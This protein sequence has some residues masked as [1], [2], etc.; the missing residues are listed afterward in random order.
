MHAAKGHPEPLNLDLDDARRRY[1]HALAP[2]DRERHPFYAELCDCLG[3]DHL[4]L[5]LLSEVRATQ[6]N[7]MLILAALQLL[8]LRRHVVLGPL[9]DRVRRGELV[10]VTTDVET[11][12]NVLHDDPALVRGELWRS[13]QT[14]E[15]GR[16]AV[17]QALVSELARGQ[18]VI[19]VIEVGS[20]A[21]IN[22]HFERFRVRELDDHDALTLEC[23]DLGGAYERTL[24][25]IARRVGI[26]PNPLELANLDDQQWLKACLWPEDRRRHE[27]FDAVVAAWPTWEPVEVL[28]GSAR[29][30]FDEALALTNDAF[31]IIVNTWVLFYLSDEER[32]WFLARAHDAAREGGRATIS[33][34]S[35]L[36]AIEGIDPTQRPAQR[37]ASRI[38][39]AREFG[40]PE[41]WGWCHPHG[42]WLEKVHS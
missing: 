19:N 34:E 27:R 17:L 39:V 35:P 5:T 31:T 11:V 9:Y 18:R 40:A 15:P 33:V 37:G 6:R 29:E 10:D 16:S 7:P 21:G 32:A 4:G 30:R 14:N 8:A 26:D 36:V 22:L 41:L 24:P 23:R 2:E 12:L 25:S 42:R 3:E 1:E 38:V 20:S 13:T 28:R